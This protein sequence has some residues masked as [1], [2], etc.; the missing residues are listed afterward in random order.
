[1]ISQIR[2]L[3]QDKLISGINI[4]T[5]NGVDILGSGDLTV[6]GS[7]VSD[8]DKGDITVSGSGSV[9][10]IDNNA[11]TNAKVNDVSV[12][13]VTGTKSEFDTACTD[14]NFL[15]VGNLS[16]AIGI[17]ID[18][19]SSTITTGVKGYIVV[20]NSRTITGW[21]IVGSPSGSIVVDVWKANASIPTVANTITGTEKPTLS[22]S[23]YNSDLSLS[24]WSTS[25]VAGDVIA[26]NV[27]SASSITKATIT[28]VTTS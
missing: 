24:S 14:G 11:V 21:Y 8:G 9:W 2:K 4:K 13:K 26:F 3:I 1:M 15:F 20:P 19:G 17:T 16:G 10:T 28:I 25:L 22:S 7:G 6:T 23:Q 5:I 27:D 18:G 12:T